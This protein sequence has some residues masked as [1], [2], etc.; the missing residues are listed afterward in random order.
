ME[1]KILEILSS[2][3]RPRGVDTNGD[4]YDFVIEEDDFVNVAKE[5]NMITNTGGFKDAILEVLNDN[6]VSRDVDWRRDAIDFVVRTEDFEYVKD[7]FIVK[8]ND[9]SY[10]I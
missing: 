8:F 1:D 5:V 9:S 2:Y 10:W 7:E 3:A 6:S 4:A